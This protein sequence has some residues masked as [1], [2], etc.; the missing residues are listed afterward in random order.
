MKTISRFPISVFGKS[1]FVAG[2]AVVMAA[3]ASAQRIKIKDAESGAVVAECDVD[4]PAKVKIGGKSY[5]IERAE[6]SAT[7]KKARQIKLPSCHFEGSHLDESI[8]FLRLRS[9]QLDITEVEPSDK[10]INMRIANP[11]LKSKVISS[12]NLRNAS[13]YEICQAIADQIDSDV[14]FG[15]NSIVFKDKAKATQKPGSQ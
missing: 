8:D 12:L 14:V 7:E 15:E 9:A 3:T 10:G 4:T 6:P 5:L 13:I 11:K 2:I 1:A